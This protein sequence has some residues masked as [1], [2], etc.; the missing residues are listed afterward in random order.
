M[1]V[2][3]LTVLA[4]PFCMACSTD[5]NEE[6]PGLNMYGGDSVLPP[7]PGSSSD[8]EQEVPLGSDL[9]Q[10]AS[11]FSA[12]KKGELYNGNGQGGYLTRLHSRDYNLEV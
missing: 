12:K 3:C 4:L 9:C 6:N 8:G 10:R 11:T 5:K 7:V 2:D 1:S